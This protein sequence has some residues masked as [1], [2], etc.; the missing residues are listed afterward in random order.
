MVEA[1]PGRDAS[2]PMSFRRAT[3]CVLVPFASGYYLSYLFRTISA[4]ISGRMI[5]ELHLVPA[6]LGLLTSAYFFT[7]AVAQLPWAWRWTATGRAGYRPSCSRWR[8]GAPGCLRSRT[9]SRCWHSA[10]H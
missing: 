8:R 3:L 10:V 7:F 5:A 2:R 9:A 1:E 4:L 6:D